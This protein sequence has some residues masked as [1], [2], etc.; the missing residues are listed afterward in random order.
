[1]WRHHQVVQEFCCAY[2]N[3]G[4]DVQADSPAHQQAFSIF[5]F[6]YTFMYI[7]I[8]QYIN[9]ISIIYI[10]KDRQKIYTADNSSMS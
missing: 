2:P 10:H 1:M 6:T 9:I 8:I 5:R 4:D 3:Q 7:Y